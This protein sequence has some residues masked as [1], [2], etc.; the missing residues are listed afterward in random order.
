M[1]VIN[2]SIP[3]DCPDCGCGSDSSSSGSG[4]SGGSITPVQCGESIMTV[5]IHCVREADPTIGIEADEIDVVGYVPS[6]WFAIGDGVFNYDYEYMNYT[7]TIDAI[8]DQ[9]CY[10]S[11]SEYYEDW[12]AIPVNQRWG[13]L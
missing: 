11:I 7:C 10:D 6:C 4:S 5:R 8:T 9:I 1:A 13:A 12:N 3:W 2:F